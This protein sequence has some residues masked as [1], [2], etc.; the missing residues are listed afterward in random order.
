VTTEEVALRVES[1]RRRAGDDEAAH[2]DEDRLWEDVLRAIAAGTENPAA[3]ASAALK[4]Q[5]I[6]FNRWCA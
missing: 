1:V 4:T 5:D 3:L 2:S 6:D